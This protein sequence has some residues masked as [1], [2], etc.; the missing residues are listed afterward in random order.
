ML[1]SICVSR[2][3]F[4]IYNCFEMEAVLHVLVFWWYVDKSW[5]FCLYLAYKCLIPYIY[6]WFSILLINMIKNLYLAWEAHTTIFTR[7]LNNINLVRCACFDFDW[8]SSKWI[9]LFTT[10]SS[11]ISPLSLMLLLNLIELCIPNAYFFP[12]I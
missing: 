9:D 10:S 7:F 11:L 5:M 6:V 8:K 2:R 12:G 1:A 4:L 3:W